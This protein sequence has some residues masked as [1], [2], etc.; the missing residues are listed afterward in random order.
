MSPDDVETSYTYGT[1]AALVRAATGNYY[2][3][4]TPDIAGRWWFRCETTGPVSAQEGDF[5]V[6]A[7]A[8]VDQRLAR[9]RYSV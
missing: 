5:L 7:S 6:Q 4:V 9:K 3:D 1:D 2:V 8:F